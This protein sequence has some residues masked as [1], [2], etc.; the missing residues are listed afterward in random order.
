M[1][2]KVTLNG[3][4]VTAMVDTGATH[5]LISDKVARRLPLYPHC[6]IAASSLK[7]SRGWRPRAGSYHRIE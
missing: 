7:A 2:T 1:Y 6:E 3:R 4:E 5:N